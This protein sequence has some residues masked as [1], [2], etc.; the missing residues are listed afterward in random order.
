MP[1]PKKGSSAGLRVKPPNRMTTP[2]RTSKEKEPRG[3][4]MPAEPA[5]INYERWDVGGGTA[6]R[7]Y[8]RGT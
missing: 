8:G 3:D 2:P 1:H 7:L 6:S 5:G 4:H